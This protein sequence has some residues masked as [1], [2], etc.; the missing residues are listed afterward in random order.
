MDRIKLNPNE[1]DLPEPLKR[2]R[3]RRIR[4]GCIRRISQKTADRFIRRFGGQIFDSDIDLSVFRNPEKRGM[5]YIHYSYY[6]PGT[7]GAMC[8]WLGIAEI[9]EEE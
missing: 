3:D 1:N 6:A 4:K 5:L 7:I 8:L 9:E 2:L